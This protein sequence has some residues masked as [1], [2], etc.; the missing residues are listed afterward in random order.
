MTKIWIVQGST[1]EYS[2]HR[3]WMVCAYRDEAKAEQHARA[4]KEWYQKNGCDK[5]D[6][7]KRWEA[8]EK[9]LHNPFDP[10]MDIDYTGTDWTIFEVNLLDRLPTE[11]NP[12]SN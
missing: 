5:W 10:N 1:G 9:G 6:F 11:K 2:D 4:A 8:K 12:S 3:E 7:Q